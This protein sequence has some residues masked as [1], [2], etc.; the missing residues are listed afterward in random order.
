[1]K[2]RMSFCLG[3]LVVLS[4]PVR[5]Q[6]AETLSNNFVNIYTVVSYVATVKGYCDGA[7]P[8]SK[9]SNAAALDSWKKANNTSQFENITVKFIQKFPVVSDSLSAIRSKML[10]RIKQSAAGREAAFCAQLPG[11]LK[12]PDT[13]VGQKYK[14]EIAQ[15]AQV[16]SGTP[17][18]TTTAQSGSSS[19]TPPAGSAT[20]VKGAEFKTKPGAGLKLSQ[21][22]GLYYVRKQQMKMD[23]FGNSY[24]KVDEDTYLALRDG[25]VYSYYWGFP[26]EDFNAA[27][28]KRTEPK[29][30]KSR[31]E[32]EQT[33]KDAWKI[34]PFSKGF[35]LNRSYGSD[36]SGSGGTYSGRS[37]GFKSDGTFSYF[38]YAGIAGKTAGGGGDVGV[39]GGGSSST[40]TTN[41][42]GSGY[43]ATTPSTSESTGKYNIEGYA[44]TI[45]FAD[46]T[47]SRF[48]FGV[49]EVCSKTKLRDVFFKGTYW[50][51]G[52]EC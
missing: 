34:L 50:W 36:S 33:L 24:L 10:V 25:S 30:W 27:L 32:L 37:I 44:L 22:E 39:T 49:S 7:V 15:L 43:A 5:A 9:A 40:V 48:V 23:G 47:V 35:T 1:M 11:L 16:V 14:A 42:D 38:G 45:K 3:L 2:A 13:Q 51:G 46:G 12:N 52:G 4:A 41:G 21:I 26:P 19:T 28:S 18:A 17:T 8:A 6:D 20:A 31:A 29:K